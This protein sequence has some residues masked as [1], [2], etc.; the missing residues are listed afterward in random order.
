MYTSLVFLSQNVPEGR[1][2]ALDQQML[3]SAI[4]QLLNGI[5]LAVAL[6]Y[7]LYKPV[8]SFME[9]RTERIQSKID[10]SDE[11]MAKANKL[12]AEYESKVAN[13]D[14]EYDKVLEKARIDAAEERRAIIAEANKEA[15]NIKERAEGVIEAERERV[16]LETR[17]YIIELATLM[18][19]NYITQHI[20][21]EEQDKLFDEALTQLEE[22][23]W[24]K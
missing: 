3:I 14:K 24:Q 10:G 18:A 11:T 21:Q 1:L 2:F 22:A 7:I 8:K 20:E 6:A 4:I 19:Q 16:K 13:I 5:I 15:E 23:Q 17:P 9:K 12:I